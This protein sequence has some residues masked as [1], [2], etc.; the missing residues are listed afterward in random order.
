ML[1]DCLIVGGGPAG[2]SAAVY[3]GRFLRRTLVL[4]G[5]EGRSSFEQVNDNYLGFPDGIRVRDLRKLGI[6]QAERFGVEVVTCRAQR[7][8]RTGSD[9]TAHTDIGSFTGRTVILCTGVCDIWPDLPDVLDYVGKTLFWCITCDGFRALDKRLVLFGQNDDAATSAC[10][11]QV[12]TR[13]ITFVTPP[14]K[15]ECS[16][17]KVQDM[18]RAGVKMTEGIPKSL[19]GTP[20][21]IGAVVLDDGRRLPADLMF[22]LL[23]V[24]PNN[25]LGVDLGLDLTRE[26]YIRVD[27][28]GYTSVPGIFAAGDISNMHTHQVVSAAHEG[29]EAAQ[30]A[31]YYLYADHQKL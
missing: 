3:M 14:G 15:L 6:K 26:G 11:F 28:E 31:N 1:Y 16:R 29:A 12:Y 10:Q 8:E 24:N 27:E 9:F 17:E 21:E 25:Q 22:S 5:G 23:G 4:D 13:N 19:D 18:E 7:L 20:E 2:L 30:T